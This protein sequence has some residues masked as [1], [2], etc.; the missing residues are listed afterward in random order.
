M[1]ERGFGRILNLTS[2]AG[3]R[4]GPAVQG[5]HYIASKAGIVGITRYLAYELGPSGV[6]VNAIAPGPTLTPQ[7][8]AAPP[9]KLEAVRAQVPARRLGTVEEVAAVAVF[10]AS[11][12]AGFVNGAVIDVNGGLLMR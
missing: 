9:E 1:S 7:T 5:I 4:G 12:A 6:T 3:L 2:I 10:L 11:D 8:A